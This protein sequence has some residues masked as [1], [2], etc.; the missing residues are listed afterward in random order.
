MTSVAARRVVCEHRGVRRVCMSTAILAACQAP[1][2]THAPVVAVVAAP[3]PPEPRPAPPQ[4]PEPEPEPPVPEDSPPPANALVLRAAMVTRFELDLYPLAGGGLAAADLFD[5][6]G[7]AGGQATPTRDADYYAYTDEHFV[8]PHAIGGRW[9]GEVIVTIDHFTLRAT[10]LYEVIVRGPAAW[11]P[12]EMRSA[13]GRLDYYM[14]YAGTP[15]GQVFGL[16]VGQPQRGFHDSAIG[17]DPGDDEMPDFGAPTPR[18]HR[19]DSGRWLYW[20]GAPV[21]ERLAG[22]GP[23]PPALPTR[24]VALELHAA[25][26]GGLYVRALGGQILHAAPG[27]RGW[28]TLPPPFAWT[29]AT[30][31]AM[32]VG[33]DGRL[34]VAQCAKGSDRLHRWDGATWTPLPP[35]P[36][37]PDAFVAREGGEVWALTDAL[38]R[39][40]EDGAWTERPPH[41][42][43]YPPLSPH[44]LAA[45][46]GALWVSGEVETPDGG[47][48]DRT[49][50]VL[51]TT[52]AG[53]ALLDL[54]HKPVLPTGVPRTTR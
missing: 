40:G 16:R 1:E 51:A 50:T 4:E 33:L 2:P 19:D 45:V 54:R 14:A 21:V 49:E 6:V 28:R 13:R 18:P 52:L 42:P 53:G 32:T 30:S 38:L 20:F 3:E 10:S 44:A 48:N 34:L 43:G 7:V 25:P 46:P 29:K 39:L 11:G 24:T 37:C 27:A 5:L 17:Y 31:M 12:R 15:D 22:A 35:L 9:P 26:A 8:R 23:Q 36:A 41:V 47:P